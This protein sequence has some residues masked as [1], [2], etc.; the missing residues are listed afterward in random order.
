[1]GIIKSGRVPATYGCRKH[2]FEARCTNAVT[3][4]RDTLE[5]QLLQAITEKLRPEI[6]DDSLGHLQAQ[7]AN[8]LDKERSGQTGADVASL[9]ARLADLTSQEGNLVR[10][11]ARHGDSEALMS[12]LATVESY[13]K[14]VRRQLSH[15]VNIGKT[16]RETVSFD[17]FRSFVIE[18]A[19]NLESVLRGD[20]VV[21]RETLR[22]VIRRLVL[23]PVQTP[24]GPAFEVTG[25]I[26]LF[27]AGA[28]VMLGSSVDQTAKHYTPLLSL[29]GVQLDPNKRAQQTVTGG[30]DRNI[31]A[32]PPLTGVE[33][34]PS[35]S[36]ALAV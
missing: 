21:A 16:G 15:S 18:K 36:E 33:T 8:Y 13:V 31:L 19:G 14:D 11:I 3:I 17:Q 20:P 5:E 9:E 23:T 25:D 2:R 32:V 26:D 28:G 4:R 34:A 1:M 29:V 30:D 27:A 10:A 35:G 7:I 6:L 22:K 12:E 24:S